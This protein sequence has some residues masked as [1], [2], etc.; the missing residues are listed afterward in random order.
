MQGDVE[1]VHDWRKH[2]S[3]EELKRIVEANNWSAITVGS[4]GHA[5]LKSFDEALA[6][7]ERRHEAEFSRVKTEHDVAKL[8]E[9]RLFEERESLKAEKR[10]Q[11]KLIDALQQAVTEK[12]S[13][14]AAATKRQQEMDKQH[15]VSVQALKEAEETQRQK[16][17]AAAEQLLAL[18]LSC[19]TSD[20]SPKKSELP[21]TATVR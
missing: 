15:D 11:D 9:K 19:V 4:F 16:A 3:L 1:I 6:D 8:S 7:A 12:E 2:K 17:S 21:S 14:I 10:T 5:A 18:V 13:M 20:V